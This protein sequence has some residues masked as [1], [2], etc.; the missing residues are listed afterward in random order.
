MNKRKRSFT[1]E[2]NLTPLL[3]ALFS[4]LFIVMLSGAQS[5]RVMQEE[6]AK[7]LNSSVSALE[8]N[9]QQLKNDIKTLQNINKTIKMFEAD[10]VIITLENI[11]EDGRYILKT[12]VG[13]NKEPY[14]DDLDLGSDLQLIEDSIPR[15]IGQTIGESKSRRPVYIVFH[16]DIK[17]ILTKELFS[18]KNMLETLENE[19]SEVFCKIVE[20]E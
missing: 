18:I 2:I 3:D 17:N 15:K 7:Q 8:K 6:A 4:I 10:A 12:F 9:N 16:C 19:H 20:E 11:N 5:E 14:F 1:E 13:Q